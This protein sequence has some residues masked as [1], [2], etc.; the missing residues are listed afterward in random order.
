MIFIYADQRFMHC[1]VW[2]DKNLCGTNLCDRHLTHIIRI[3]KTHAEKCRFTVI[4]SYTTP[5]KF[6]TFNYC[7][8]STKLI[9]VKKVSNIIGTH[10]CYKP[11][12]KQTKHTRMLSIYFQILCMQIITIRMLN[13]TVYTH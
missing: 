8:P 3:N 6:N 9:M 2:R 10:V 13:F 11:L 5:I 1:N 7:H 4:A 12:I